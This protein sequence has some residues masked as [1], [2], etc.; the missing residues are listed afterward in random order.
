MGTLEG[1]ETGGI[2]I[3]FRA[4]SG[5]TLREVALR[6]RNTLKEEKAVA[7]M[8]G[9]H[10]LDSLRKAQVF[11]EHTWLSF[12]VTSSASFMG[13]QTH[14]HPGKDPLLEED[15]VTDSSTKAS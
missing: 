14:S 11:L 13:A 6:W 4:P 8:K 9:P 7:P 12:A 5:Q 15:R 2:K 3:L 1:S 10:K